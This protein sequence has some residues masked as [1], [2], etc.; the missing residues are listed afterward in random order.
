MKKGEKIVLGSGYLYLMKFTGTVPDTKTICV[1][2][3]R[4]AY[5]QGGASV[6]YT[7]TFYEAKDDLGYAT[8]TL[9]TDES[10]VLKSGIMTWYGETLAKLC[11]TARVTTTDST[12]TVKIGGLGNYNDEKYV[13]CFHHPD[14]TDG[15]IW[16]LIVGQN[17]SGFTLAF[18]KDKETVIDA[19]FKAAASLDDE[20][21]LIQYIEEIKKEVTSEAAQTTKAVKV[22]EK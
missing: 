15:D 4:L 11:M 16:L 3:N 10:V 22:A 17:Q 5:I 18:A 6:E 21:T 2:E 7:P 1:E 20:G 8:K 9:L 12:R 14:A 13:I 19:E